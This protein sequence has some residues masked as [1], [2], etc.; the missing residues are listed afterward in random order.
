MKTTLSTLVLSALLVSGCADDR[1]T[2]TD[3][4]GNAVTVATVLDAWGEPAVGTEVV[5][6][7]AR[8]L[9]GEAVD[10]VSEHADG[11]R[12]K[13]DAFGK[14]RIPSTDSS[15][16]RMVRVG[17]IHAAAMMRLAHDTEATLWLNPVGAVQGVIARVPT[18]TKVRLFGLEGMALTDASGRF[19]LTRVP[20]GRVV[21]AVGE[22]ASMMVIDQIE[23]RPGEAVSIGSHEMAAGDTV[24]APADTTKAA[25][26]S[27]GPRFLPGPG[28]Y[29]SPQTVE[30]VPADAS[31]QVEI[32]EDGKAWTVLEGSYRVM[33]SVCLQ[34]RVVREGRIVSESVEGCYTLEP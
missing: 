5:V 1:T 27:Y 10:S 28:S 30:I 32:S 8:W 13:T 16:P 25:A 23:V 24:N 4:H 21:M 15:H 31:D 20:A 26:I 11:F 29:N 22:G 9:H 2:G 34:A 14:V 3:E 7:D 18:G 33:A 17:G 12:L 19:F 6:R